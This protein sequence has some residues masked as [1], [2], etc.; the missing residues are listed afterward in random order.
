LQVLLI[1]RVLEHR[2]RAV[3]ALLALALA[4]LGV[5]ACGGSGNSGG[6]GTTDA[7]TLLT[8]TFT[9]THAIKSGKANLDVKVTAT[10][11]PSIS[12]PIELKVAGPFQTAGNDQLPKFDL[13]LDI[14]AQG[15]GF[16]AGLTSTSDQL[17]VKFGGTAY[18]VPATLVAQMKKSFTQSQQSSK[19]GMSLGSLGIDP[20]KWLKDPTVT[21]TETVG[22][23]ETE[24]ITAGV[25]VSALLDDLD[26]V[27]GKIK[28]QLPAGVTGT[29]IPD[30][31]P[32]DTRTKI[33]DAVK[34]ATVEI[35][36]GKDDKTLRKLT[37]KLGVEPPKSAS[38]PRTLD[39]AISFELQ[40]LNQPQTI[41]APTATHPLSE[42]L[43][44]LQG[45]LGGAL[46]G[47]A[48]GGSSGSGS[49]SPNI[50]KYTKCLQD[51]Q[52]DVTKAQACASL[53]TQ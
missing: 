49:S 53:L 32:A 46:G 17:F 38:G 28:G 12:G 21:G 47:S 37:L 30:K 33:Q 20:I 15:Q 44:Q 36:T 48:L 39:I 35:W 7:K 10:G 8:Q 40:D 45:L 31:I 23:V 25:D 1:H 9:G 24:H 26:N 11:D 18:E 51:A 29:Q 43:G 13:A 27:L 6:G 41:T 34:S 42:L 2:A 19:S 5:S 14:G 4:A 3:V 22:G 16:K 52:G 50:D